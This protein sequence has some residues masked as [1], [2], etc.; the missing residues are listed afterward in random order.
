MA[1]PSGG[2]NSS[3][4]VLDAV[5]RIVG[6]TRFSPATPE[7]AAL[8]AAAGLRAVPGSSPAPGYS[9]A[10]TGATAASPYAAAAAAPKSS[11]SLADVRRRAL[12]AKQLGKD[13]AHLRKYRHFN[14]SSDDSTVHL[15]EKKLVTL[16]CSVCGAHAVV[17][18]LNIDS[19]PRRGSDEA[20]VLQVGDSFFK[21]YTAVGE[22][23]LLRRQTGVEVQ[24]RMKCRDCE[25]PLGYKAVPFEEPAQEIYFFKDALCK[26]Q[27]EAEAF[28]PARRSG[29][30]ATFAPSSL[31]LSQ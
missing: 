10:A 5:D 8:Y 9:A 16:Y 29:G 7:A 21:M 31:A 22:R 4:S 18:E 13:V 11:L 19:L 3:P 28:Q 12:E 1:S 30:S 23:T 6:G 26:E 27:S 14:Y 24:Y 20:L 25:F 17:T 2:L 15:T